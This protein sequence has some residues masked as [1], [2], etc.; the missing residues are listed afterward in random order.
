MIFNLEYITNYIDK[1][2]REN[3][4]IIVITFHEL[5]VQENLSEQQI[6]YFLDKSKIRLTNL[7][8][9]IYEEGDTYTLE[10]ET[11]LI[12]NNIYYV[13]MKNEKS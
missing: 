13:A 3:E 8:Y 2:I 1:K 12:E 11:H 10:G 5:K 7:D 6:E 4:N 9:K